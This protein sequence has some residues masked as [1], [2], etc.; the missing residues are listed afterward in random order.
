ML[1]E[2]NSGEDVRHKIRKK[3][4]KK[5][6][7]RYKAKVGSEHRLCDCAP[8]WCSGKHNGPWFIKLP[9]V[10]VVFVSQPLKFCVYAAGDPAG[11][12]PPFNL[13]C[14]VRIRCFLY[15]VVNGAVEGAA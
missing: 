12:M 11:A 6:K 9:Q 3:K 13:S 10:P 7:K 1:L 8:A 15:L 14:Q 4:E 5:K 2:W